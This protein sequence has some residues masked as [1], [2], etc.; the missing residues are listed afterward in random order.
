MSEAQSL[1]RE[2]SHSNLDDTRYLSTVNHCCSGN[3]EPTPLIHDFAGYPLRIAYPCSIRTLKRG[4]A[5]TSGFPHCLTVYG[6]AGL[7]NTQKTTRRRIFMECMRS[8]PRCPSSVFVQRYFFS[9]PFLFIKLQDILPSEFSFVFDWPATPN[10][11]QPTRFGC[12]GQP[13]T[14]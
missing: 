9:G 8:A 11:D 13:A 5:K 2:R 7:T 1:G 4:C 10:H 3:Q 6:L 14:H 12:W